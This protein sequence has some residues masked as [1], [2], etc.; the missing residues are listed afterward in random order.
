MA[1]V[2]VRYRVKPGQEER[3]AELVRAVYAELSERRPEG[4]S[5]ATFRLE[6]GRTFVHVAATEGEAPFPLAEPRRRSGSSSA[7]C[8]DRCEWGPERSPSEVVGSYRM[9]E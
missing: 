3:N 5:Y 6:D 7:S 8:R 4:F 9:L 1:I 2:I